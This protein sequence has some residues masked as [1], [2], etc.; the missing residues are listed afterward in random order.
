MTR[1]RPAGVTRNPQSD[2]FTIEKLAHDCLDVRFLRREGFFADGGVT[3]GATL[4]WPSIAR[5]R[6]A[7]YLLTLDLRGRTVPQHI[8]VSWT[9]VHL[10]G[11]RPW[12]HCPHCER[13]VARLYDGLGGYFC[14]ACIGNPPYA[15]QR[16]SAKGR[17]HYQ[18]CKL[19]LLLNGQ[20]RL[21]T[22][23]PERP[24]RMHERT[25]QRIRQV[26][27]DLEAGLSKRMRQRFPDYAN[28]VAYTD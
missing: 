3:I 1:N 13:R 12:M 23:F 14:R 20:A 18:A 7:R 22:P 4:K 15:S 5:M 27:M 16:L 28:L 6:I 10:G 9:K 21:T 2:Q 24:P 26:G 19:R 8:R 11:K 17:A 25:Y